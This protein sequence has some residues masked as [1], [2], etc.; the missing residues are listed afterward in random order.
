LFDKL[1]DEAQAYVD[2]IAERVT[3]LGGTAAGTVRMSAAA[4]RLDEYPLD[5]SQH[6]SSIVALVA[7]YAS[8]GETTRGAIDTA[9]RAGDADTADL[10]TEVSRGLDKSLWFLEAHLQSP[11]APS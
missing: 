10:L 2:L 3:A 8:L 1:A 4:S 6:L 5:V 7:A 9:D 11:D